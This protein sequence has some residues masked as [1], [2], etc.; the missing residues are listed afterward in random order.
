MKR[1][2]HFRAGT[3]F[4]HLQR[5]FSVQIPAHFRVGTAIDR[6]ELIFSG[7]TDYSYDKTGF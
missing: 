7:A 3:I 1:P 6:N 4:N 5:T 2:A